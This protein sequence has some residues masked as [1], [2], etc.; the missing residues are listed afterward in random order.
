MTQKHPGRFL[1]SQPHLYHPLLRFPWCLTFVWS[2]LP[3]TSSPFPTD[4]CL[5]SP[6]PSTVSRSIRQA[7]I[8]CFTPPA[9]SSA[10]N[11]DK[12]AALLRLSGGFSL[13]TGVLTLLANSPGI[14]CDPWEPLLPVCDTGTSHSVWT[15]SLCPCGRSSLVTSP[16]PGRSHKSSSWSGLDGPR[17]QHKPRTVR[18]NWSR[19]SRQRCLSVTLFWAR[20]FVWR[21]VAPGSWA[22]EGKCLLML[23]QG[24]SRATVRNRRRQIISGPVVSFSLSGGLRFELNYFRNRWLP[25]NF[26]LL[27]S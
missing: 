23:S 17:L 2:L 25:E 27:C 19:P 22:R 21:A 3:L 8:L 13:S 24:R 15:R 6:A 11:F 4:P 18:R 26:F 1:L 12:R 20:T 9:D 16:A 14:L 10:F 5:H 7:P